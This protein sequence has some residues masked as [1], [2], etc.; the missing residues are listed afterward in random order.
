MNDD[1]RE[2][3]SAYLDEALSAAERRDLESR[4]AAALKKLQAA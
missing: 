3:L 4:L 2:K 1:M